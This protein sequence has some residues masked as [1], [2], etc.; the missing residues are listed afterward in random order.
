V[1]CVL[2]DLPAAGRIAVLRLRSLGDC[3]LT[4]PA[5]EILKRHRPDLRV[6]VVVEGRF[7]AVFEGNPD[8]QEIQPPEVGAL[9][10][11]RPDLCLNL[12]G[13]TRSAWLTLA[14]GARWRA[15]FGH[16]RHRFVYNVRIP[17]A[18]E[19]FGVERTVH[20]AEHLASA[21]FYLGAPVGEV[22]R[23]KLCAG[24][25]AGTASTSACATI[26]PVAATAEKTWSAEG[27]LK[28]AEHLRSMGI[29]P[30][31]IGGAGDDLSAF[32]A[33]RTL[34]GAPLGEVKSLLASSC[35]FVGND[36]GP[37][38]MAAAFGLPVVVIF[39]N[40]DPAI[41]GPWRTAAEIVRSPVGV[42]GVSVD[43]VLGALA[44]LRVHA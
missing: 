26:H 15:G 35:L 12:H 24:T 29:E 33:F 16:F 38:H 4:T 6:A 23:A 31:F 3:V 7:R 43:D 13:G 20:T 28:V 44:R 41:W 8:I 19:I 30:V 34:G 42:A 36:S 40:S 18:Q 10:R 1:E 14:S 39:G 32:S 17:R 37:A 5:L 22:P 9:R 21:M 25:S 11:F 2:D 27:F